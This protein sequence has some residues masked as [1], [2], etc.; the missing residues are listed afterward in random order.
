MGAPNHKY[1]I[2][3]HSSA[4]WCALC[5]CFVQASQKRTHERSQK[6]KDAIERKMK[7]LA[8]KT[9]KKKSDYCHTLVKEGEDIDQFSIVKTQQVYH[10]IFDLKILR[11]Y[12][13]LNDQTIRQATLF[14]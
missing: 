7:D 9:A 13:N 8:N 11:M 10:L 14:K 4:D 2:S 5:K 3:A 1:S 6:H 12:I